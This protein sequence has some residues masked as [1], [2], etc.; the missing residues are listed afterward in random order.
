M[1]LYPNGCAR[2]GS[3]AFNSRLHGRDDT[4]THLCDV[5][6]W[7][8]RAEGDEDSIRADLRRLAMRPYPSVESSGVAWTILNAFT[9]FGQPCWSELNWDEQTWFI[10]MVAEAL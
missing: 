5:C 6:Y 10:L 1:S 4:D 2:C 3:Y 7:R 8:K 9:R